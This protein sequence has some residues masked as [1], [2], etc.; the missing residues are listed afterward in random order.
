MHRYFL[1]LAYD[2]THFSGWQRQSAG[3]TVQGVLEENLSKIIRT[4]TQVVGCGRTDAGVH[5]TQYY[6]HFNTQE[7]V[8]INSIAY[9]L[10]KMLRD[11]VVVQKAFEANDRIHAR[12]SA[13][14]RAYRYVIL[15]E[16]N[17]FKRKYAWFI[18]E[19][20]DI[21]RMNEAAN[22]LLSYEDFSSFARTGSDVKHHRCDVRKAQFTEKGTEL[23]F[24]IA[25][26]RFL[27]NMVRAVVGTLLDVGKG[28]LSLSDFRSVVEAKDRSLAGTSAK[29]HGLYLHEI[30]Y[31][32][33]LES[34]E[35]A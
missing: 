25:A 23:H 15:R 34:F 22:T 13:T 11:E 26:D 5:A 4:S 30:R 9:K 27:R 21:D 17:P 8:D 18:Q 7:E 35:N 14:E 19:P 6:A 3:K 10:N 20:L 28:K 1:K 31:N 33:L 32:A 2:G 24:D 16:K 29:A 12:Y